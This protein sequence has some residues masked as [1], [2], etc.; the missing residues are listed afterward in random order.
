[1]KGGVW[2]FLRAYKT[3]LCCV[4]VPCCV[5]SF[6]PFFDAR[7]CN[8]SLLMPHRLSRAPVLWS[9]SC[10]RLGVANE[11]THK[12]RN[13]LFFLMSFGAQILRTRLRRPFNGVYL[14]VVVLWT[15]SAFFFVFPLLSPHHTSFTSLFFCQLS[16][17]C[18]TPYG[19][20]S[21]SSSEFVN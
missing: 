12:K 21:L 7:F 1:M 10:V 11:G 15:C 19:G 18:Q 13:S 4:C 20:K 6:S 5:F 17:F 16:P 3:C 2:L 14:L 8:K 9:K